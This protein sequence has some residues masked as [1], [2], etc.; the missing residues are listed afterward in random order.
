MPASMRSLGRLMFCLSAVLIGARGWAL[1]CKAHLQACQTAVAEATE[2]LQEAQ[3]AL[4]E[5][6][7]SFQED[8]LAL[9]PWM[10]ALF[11]TADLGLTTLA[12]GPG[13]WPSTP[14]ASVFTAKDG[15]EATEGA[16][17]MLAAFQKRFALERGPGKT[18]VRPRLRPSQ[19]Q[20][21][22]L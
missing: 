3:T 16:E 22:L 7:A 12:V 11:A 17:K 10:N 9:T 2:K 5:V 15:A 8:A 20:S 21:A 14:A 19:A 4:Q 1:R 6:Q 13:T 18:N